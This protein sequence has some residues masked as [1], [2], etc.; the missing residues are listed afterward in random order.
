MSIVTIFLVIKCNNSNQRKKKKN[1]PP[2]PT[3]NAEPTS[4]PTSKV[5]RKNANTHRP[6]IHPRKN[7]K[8]TPPWDKAR[9]V[10]RIRDNKNVSRP[11]TSPW[12]IA[13]PM[14]RRDLQN[15]WALLTMG[16]GARCAFE[17]RSRNRRKKIQ[18]RQKNGEKSDDLSRRSGIIKRAEILTYEFARGVHAR[19]TATII[20]SGFLRKF[21]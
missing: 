21:R 20:R 13:A 4:A 15:D 18:A 9:H 12:F 3:F 14:I 7:D 16:L 1:Q 11:I 5:P 6:I 19:A 8:E 2:L 10:S 17:Q